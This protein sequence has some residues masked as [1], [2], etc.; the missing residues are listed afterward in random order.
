[1][2]TENHVRGLRRVLPPP[3]ICPA[4]PGD[5][6]VAPR[7]LS[8]QTR[9]CKDFYQLF[10]VVEERETVN[11]GSGCQLR[12]AFT[13]FLEDRRWEFVLLPLNK[14][15]GLGFFSVPRRL[16][17]GVGRR[18]QLSSEGHHARQMHEDS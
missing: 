8:L 4:P 9:S 1:M 14:L 15:W 3:S 13:T 10:E 16:E 12:P 6:S 11:M 5:N 18:D 17:H 2:A 7:L